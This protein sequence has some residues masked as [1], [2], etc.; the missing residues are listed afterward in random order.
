MKTSRIITLGLT[1][2][3]SFCA[4]FAA[5]EDEQPE[6]VL[7]APRAHVDFWLPPGIVVQSN[8]VTG[9]VF[10]DS[11]D[12]PLYVFLCDR[13]IEAAN[14]KDLL[15]NSKRET[16]ARVEAKLARA[17]TPEHPK[18]VDQCLT[19]HPPVISSMGSFQKS[20][21]T[22]VRLDD[23]SYQWA[24]KG[25]PLYRYK[26]DDTPGYPYGADVGGV[27]SQ[28][29]VAGSVF[30]PYRA[31]AKSSADARPIAPATPF[32]LAPGVTVQRK[33]M[34][35]VLRDFRGMT[36]YRLDR[37]H[38]DLNRW[39]PLLAGS[40]AKPIGDWTIIRDEGSVLQWAYKGQPLYTCAGDARPGDQSCETMS[41]H[42]LRFADSGL[43]AK[44][45]H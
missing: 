24:Y 8:P 26:H 40:I 30:T 35:F 23:G 31:Q 27:W 15:G 29:T 44:E 7:F 37:G 28:A 13:K 36:L 16:C 14:E 20:D 9:L 38:T 34:G 11:E 41:A 42:V 18:C 19:E 43:A 10:A 5:A 39:R 2:G 25:R 21:W 32:T 6:I 12:M 22:S 4:Q 17:L 3:L 45:E 33:P 1:L